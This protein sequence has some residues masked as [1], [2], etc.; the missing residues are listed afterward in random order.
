[1]PGSLAGIIVVA[2]EDDP[3]SLALLTIIM[4]THG[5]LVVS[6]SDAQSALEKLR[7]L[8]PTVLVSDM[9]MPYRNGAW[10]VTEARRAGLLA[11]VPALVVTAFQM[12]PQ[13]VREAGFDAYLRKPVDPTAL[14]V[15]V[16]RLAR[17]VA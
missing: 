8:R 17:R 5:A 9:S 16:R 2:V 15:T 7:R 13:E 6:A 11:G 14:C 1:M 3:D 4:E 12:T 10:L